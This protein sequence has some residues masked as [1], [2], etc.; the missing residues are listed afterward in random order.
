MHY[1]SY[2]SITLNMN[3]LFNRLKP[4]LPNYG[5]SRNLS[6]HYHGTQKIV[7]DIVVLGIHVYLVYRFVKTSFEISE[8][9]ENIKI[10]TKKTEYS[11]FT[12]RQIKDFEKQ[13]H[14]VPFEYETIVEHEW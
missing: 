8:I 4:K 13:M 12:K 7:G 11:E 5:M 2:M 3:R 6:T 14:I 10:F 9:N 1:Y